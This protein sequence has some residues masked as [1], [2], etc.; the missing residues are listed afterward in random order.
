VNTA[1]NFVSGWVTTARNEYR[2]RNDE[3]VI[4]FLALLS[5]L[6]RHAG[7]LEMPYDKMP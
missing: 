7:D 2:D 3:D 1:Q 5:T 4:T 6:L